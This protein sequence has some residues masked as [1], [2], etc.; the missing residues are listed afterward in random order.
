MEI[1]IRDAVLSDHSHIVDFQMAMALETEELILE[2]NTLSKGVKAVLEDPSKARYFIAEGEGKPVGMLMITTEW[3]DW[4]NRWV[5]WIQSVY[6]LPECRKM[7]V[8]KML[9]EHVRVIVANSDS[10]GGIRL[11]VDRRNTRA[12][13]VYT[14]LGMNGDHYATFEWMKE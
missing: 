6:I 1:L 10:I 2:Q 8:Y 7:G 5:W 9:Y 3:S 12:Q 11:Y 13:A 4:R 14:N